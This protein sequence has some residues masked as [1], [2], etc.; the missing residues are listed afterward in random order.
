MEIYVKELKDNIFN[1]YI[2]PQNIAN[3][4]AAYIYNLNRRKNSL[5]EKLKTI[6]Y[7]NENISA[8]LYISFTR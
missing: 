8:T 4:A 7:L 2:T 6:E 3:S 1:E 5:D